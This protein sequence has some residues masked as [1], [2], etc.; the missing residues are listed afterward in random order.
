[1]AGARETAAATAGED[2]DG[3][4]S[5]EG[6]EKRLLEWDNGREQNNVAKLS[7]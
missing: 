4:K 5:D 7:K 1:M 3:R 2:K 6:K